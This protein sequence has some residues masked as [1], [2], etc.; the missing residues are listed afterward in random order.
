MAH[1][2]TTTL[3][4][5]DVAPLS[6]VVRALSLA[7]KANGTV[8]QRLLH[9][10]IAAGCVLALSACQTGPSASSPMSAHHH[11]KTPKGYVSFCSRNVD[12]CSELTLK[13]VKPRLTS[14]R[15]HELQWVQRE[16][17]RSIDYVSD[18]KL[19]S[20]SDHWTLPDRKGDCEEFAIEKRRRLIELGWP[21]NALLLAVAKTPNGVGHLVLVVATDK[22]DYVL[23]NRQRDVKPWSWLGYRWISRQSQERDVD[24]VSLRARR[25]S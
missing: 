10:A 19:H 24:W 21:R 25:K 20:K 17:N 4:T 2:A 16:V 18:R 9:A 7:T 15:Y 8:V 1:S 23:D 6:G 3:P 13:P 11:V 12:Q 22:G 5:I 14:D